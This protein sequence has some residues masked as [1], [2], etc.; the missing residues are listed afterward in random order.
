[1]AEEDGGWRMCGG[2]RWR[3]REKSGE[4]K[5]VRDLVRMFVTGSSRVRGGL[6]WYLGV[7]G[8]EGELLASCRILGKWLSSRGD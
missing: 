5:T 7:A 2:R 4:G 8:K 6:N 1:M 3:Q